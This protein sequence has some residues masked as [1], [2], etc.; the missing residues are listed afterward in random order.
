MRHT[1]IVSDVHLWQGAPDAGLGMG[2]IGLVDERARLEARVGIAHQDD[3]RAHVLE[4]R[5]EVQPA[6]GKVE[7]RVTQAMPVDL[8]GS[9]KLALYLACDGGDRLFEYDAKAAN[10]AETTAATIRCSDS[11][12][13]VATS[14][15]MMSRLAV[16]SLA[17]RA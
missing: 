9:G 14:A 3:L 11:R 7:G 5:D 8:A 13:S 1:V 6:A 15:T 4:Q 16:K 10:L 2:G 17:G 12:C